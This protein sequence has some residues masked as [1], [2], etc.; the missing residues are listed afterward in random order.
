MKVDSHFPIK[1]SSQ[2]VSSESEATMLLI[3]ISLET[4][5]GLVSEQWAGA[6]GPTSRGTRCRPAITADVGET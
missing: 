4:F 1:T 6:S 5:D 2:C 3:N